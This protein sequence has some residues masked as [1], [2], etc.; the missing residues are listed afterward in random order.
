MDGSAA[1]AGSPATLPALL[2]V[3]PQPASC[4]QNRSDESGRPRASMA[5]AIVYIDVTPPPLRSAFLDHPSHFWINFPI[6]RSI[7]GNDAPKAARRGLTTMSHCRPIS[8][9]CSRNASRIRRL[10]RLRTTDP[11]IARGT[12]SPRRADLRAGSGRAR[13]N[14]ANKGPERRIPLS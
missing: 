2:R 10:M 1:G 5:R 6:A 8:A 13:Q 9:R 11:P 7:S 3:S 4:I 12:V 14:A